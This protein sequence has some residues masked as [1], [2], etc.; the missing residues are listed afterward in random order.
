MAFDSISA[1]FWSS[2][3]LHLVGMNDKG[4]LIPSIRVFACDSIANTQ[5]VLC[6]DQHLIVSISIG[7][8]TH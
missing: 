7:S 3:G 4:G 8:L 1:S 6:H 5:R 2:L